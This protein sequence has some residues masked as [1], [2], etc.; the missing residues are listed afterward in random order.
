MSTENPFMSIESPRGS[1]E[2][3]ISYIAN[4]TCPECG[5]SLSP[6]LEQ[7]RCQGRCGIDWQ[8]VWNRLKLA[9]S[10][11]SALRRYRA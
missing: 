6:S 11:D 5:G 4:Y 2:S 3:L 7:F 1:R 8:P 10:A 9:G